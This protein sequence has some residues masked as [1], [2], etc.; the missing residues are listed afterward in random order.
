MRL[1]ELK[2][3]R[4]K[5][6]TLNQEFDLPSVDIYD[7][8]LNEKLFKEFVVSRRRGEEDKE[9]AKKRR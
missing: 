2:F 8:E 7:E 1:E 9:N 4:A 5:N 3:E 6:S